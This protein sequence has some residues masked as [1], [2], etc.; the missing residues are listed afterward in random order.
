MLIRGAIMLS[1]NVTRENSAKK[2]I[3]F[4]YLSIKIAFLNI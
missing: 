4:K 1:I 2:Y 3:I